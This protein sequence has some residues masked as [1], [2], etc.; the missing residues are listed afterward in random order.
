MKSKQS[1]TNMR[2]VT[3]GAASKD[4]P[5]NVTSSTVFRLMGDS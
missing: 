3:R 2:Y 5:F 4:S 1:L